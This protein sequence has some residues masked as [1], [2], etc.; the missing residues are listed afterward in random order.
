MTHS[1]TPP[2]TAESLGP[3]P[4]RFDAFSDGVIAIA[5]TLLILE[6]KVPEAEAG[7]LWHELGR[8]WPSYAAFAVSFLTIGIMWVNHHN[9]SQRLVAVNHGLVYLNLLLLGAISFL[10]FPTAV[11][12]DYLRSGGDNEKA[13]AGLYAL[14]MIFVSAAFT[15]MWWWLRRH[16]EIVKPDRTADLRRQSV[17]SASAIGIYALVGAVSFVSA[18]AALTMFAIIAL[19][20]TFNRLK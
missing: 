10:P 18:Y 19:A 4:E 15:A 5:I 2:G 16:P 12:A 3:K 20:F 1:L 14:A 7:D 8:L 13:A 11:L 17:T 6:I 9:L